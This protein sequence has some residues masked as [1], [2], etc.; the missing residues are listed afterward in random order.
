[1]LC[2][3]FLGWPSILKRLHMLHMG[4]LHLLHHKS[5]PSATLVY[6]NLS[7]SA[8][9]HVLL[10]FVCG[11][12]NWFSGGSINSR[13]IRKCP[14]NN[15]Q[16]KLDSMKLYSWGTPNSV[17][18]TNQS[19]VAPSRVDHRRIA[20]RRAG[21]S[22]VAIFGNIGV[23]LFVASAWSIWRCWCGTYFSWQVHCLVILVCHS[24]WQVQRFCGIGALR[25]TGEMSHF[26]SWRTSR[27]K[28][29]L[30]FLKHSQITKCCIF[31]YRPWQLMRGSWFAR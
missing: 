24:S 26:R 6:L 27:T 12:D 25:V 23:S 2:F 16:F 14:L 18:S 19:R 7:K 10:W 15:Q 29:I 20:L 30:K 21:S 13:R 3:V 17:N 11:S 9:S 31:A 8:E 22:N 5:A 28:C 4:N 1:M